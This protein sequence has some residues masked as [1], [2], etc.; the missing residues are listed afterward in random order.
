MGDVAEFSLK[1]SLVYL[2]E[3]ASTIQF[4][5]KNN[6]FISMQWILASDLLVVHELHIWLF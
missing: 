4:I 6:N 3:Y 5:H 2:S 1:V